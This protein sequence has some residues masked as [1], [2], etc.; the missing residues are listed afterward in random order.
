MFA[1]PF[2]TNKIAL[3]LFFCFKLMERQ[4]LIKSRSKMPKVPG[5]MQTNSPTSNP[6]P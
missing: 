2:I 3:H 4:E 5:N 1:Y 6:K